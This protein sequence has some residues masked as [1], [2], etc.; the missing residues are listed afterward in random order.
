[1]NSEAIDRRRT[2]QEI[3]ALKQQQQSDAIPQAWR[4]PAD[5]TA[6]YEEPYDRHQHRFMEADVVGRSGILSQHEIAI[7]SEHSVRS[8][9]ESLKEGRLSSVE[10][11]TA[12]CKRAAIAQ[13][14]VRNVLTWSRISIHSFP[15]ELCFLGIVADDRYLFA[16]I[17]RRRV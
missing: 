12:F 10:V 7:T 9:L 1:M 13:Q 11:T 14:L 17:G 4:L 8:L 3:V 5:I 2:W 6:S 15:M 16:R